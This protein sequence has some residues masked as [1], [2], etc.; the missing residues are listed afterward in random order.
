MLHKTPKE[1]TESSESYCSYHRAQYYPRPY[2]YLG[3][4]VCKAGGLK[5]PLCVVEYVLHYTICY[6]PLYIYVYKHVYVHIY[7]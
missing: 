4:G 7:I 5:R 3:L 1:M 2:P 6:I